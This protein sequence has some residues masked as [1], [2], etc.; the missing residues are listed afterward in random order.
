MKFTVA[1]STMAR[2]LALARRAAAKSRWGGT[3]PTDTVLLNANGDGKLD[4]VTTD[5]ELA[6]RCHIPVTVEESGSI[7]LPVDLLTDLVKALSSDDVAAELND[8]NQVLSLI[9]GRDKAQVHSISVQEFPAV[10]MPVDEPTVVIAP[11]VLRRMI[12]QVV[13]AASEDESRPILAGVLLRFGSSKLTMVGADGYRLAKA[14][15]D[16]EDVEMDEMDVVVP[17]RAIKELRKLIAAEQQPI[18]L[19]VGESRIIFHVP[20]G[21]GRLKG[22]TEIDLVSKAIEGTYPNYSQLIPKSWTTRVVMSITELI[23]ALRPLRALVRAGDVPAVTLYIGES[24]I[25]SAW[26]RYGYTKEEKENSDRG[27]A[28]V[29]AVI[30]GQGQKKVCLNSNYLWDALQSVK[31]AGADQV[32][33]EMTTTTNPVVLRPESSDGCLYLVMPMRSIS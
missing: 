24:V 18:A 14:T 30:E 22:V 27:K 7:A 32:A 17:I 2:A 1:R 6:I 3:V 19:Y 11:D 33:M 20:G 29:N 4:L 9:S 12:D 26:I 8:E 25:L 16:A 23:T 31:A 15:V 28:K 21:Q 13:S 10:P 5:L